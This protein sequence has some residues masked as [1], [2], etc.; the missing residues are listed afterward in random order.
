VQYW[1]GKKSGL[2]LA[3]ELAVS[4]FPK[5]VYSADSCYTLAG[6]FNGDGRTDI[7]VGDMVFFGDPTPG[8][9]L[10][11][12]GQS[13][14]VWGAEAHVAS[15]WNGDGISDTSLR[16]GWID[17]LW[18][19]PPNSIATKVNCSKTFNLNGDDKGDCVVIASFARRWDITAGWG[20]P[21]GLGPMT[22]V[23][24]LTPL[25]PTWTQTSSTGFAFIDAIPADVNGDGL[26]DIVVEAGGTDQELRNIWVSL[27]GTLH[28]V[29][30]PPKSGPR[31]GPS[32]RRLY[33]DGTDLVTRVDNGVGGVIVATYQSTSTLPD[34]AAPNVAGSIANVAPR[35]V[36]SSLQ[37]QNSVALVE[38]KQYAYVRGMITRSDFDVDEDEGF[39]VVRVKDSQTNEE[40]VTHYSSVGLIGSSAWTHRLPSVVEHYHSSGKL[41]QSQQ[42]SYDAAPLGFQGVFGP[43]SENTVEYEQGVV[44]RSIQKSYSYSPY[45]AV[46]QERECFAGPTSTPSQCLLT[47]T[48]VTDDQQRWLLNRVDAIRK[49][50]ENGVILDWERRYYGPEPHLLQ[51]TEKLLCDDSETCT[52]TPD[53]G[54]PGRVDRTPSPARWV[55]VDQSRMYDPAGDLLFHR[56]ALNH[57]TLYGY[58]YYTSGSVEPT[59]I[60]R[61]VTS[62]GMDL[63]IDITKT[64]GTDG[65]LGTESNESHFITTYRYDGLGRH[66]RTEY[67]DGAAETLI[68]ANVGKIDLVNPG[69]S[70]RVIIVNAPT[71]LGTPSLGNLFGQWTEQIFDGWGVVYQQRSRGDEGHVI[72]SERREE[73]QGVRVVTYTKPHFAGP[74]PEAVRVA[75]LDGRPTDIKRLTGS[76]TTLLRSYQYFTDHISVDDALGNRTETW[77]DE[78]SRV[79]VVTD[80]LFTSTHYSH[81][82]ADRIRLI[83]LANGDGYRASYD[84]WGRQ[85]TLFETWAGNS[86]STYDDV[87][88]LLTRTDDRPRSVTFTFDE[89][90]RKATATTSDGTT[91]FSYDDCPDG[92]GLLCAVSAFDHSESFSYDE[93]ARIRTHA[94]TD[95]QT[96]Q[97]LEVGY[98]YDRYGDLQGKVLP[99]TTQ[100]SYLRTDSGNLQSI[101]FYH[102]LEIASFGDYNALGKPGFRTDGAGIT[103]SYFYNPEGLLEQAT[104]TRGLFGSEVNRYA[105]GYDALGNVLSITDQ[106][107]T[108]NVDESQTF[109]YDPLLRLKTANGPYGSHNYQYD[110]S[111]IP[112]KIGQL[113]VERT[114]KRL[115]G[116]QKYV[117]ATSPGKITYTVADQIIADHDAAG[118]LTTAWSPTGT[119]NYEYNDEGELARVL[120]QGQPTLE[121]HYDAAGERYKKVFLSPG[122]D[123]IITLYLDG[124]ELRLKG[125]SAA[126][127]IHIGAP[128]VGVVASLT[129]GSV[130]ALPSIGTLSGLIGQP[131]AGTTTGGLI[132]G[133]QYYHANHI[134]S[135]SVVTDGAGQ[136]IGRYEYEPYGS[137]SNASRGYRSTNRSFTGQ[138]L[139][140]ETGL[141]YYGARY[142]LPIM[143]RF[144]SPD[145]IIPGGPYRPAALNRYA[146]VLNNPIR[147]LDPNGHGD[148][149]QSR[150]WWGAVA[151]E[152]KG[153][154][155]G[156]ARLLA[157]SDRQNASKLFQHY[158]QGTGTPYQLSEI[159]RQWQDWIVRDTHGKPGLHHMNPYDKGMYDLQNTLGHF[160]VN[161]VKNKDGSKTYN[162][163]DYYDFPAPSSERERHGFG[164]SDLKG[165]KLFAVMGMLPWTVYQAT[166]GLRERWEIKKVGK[167]M[168]LFIPQ[169]WLKSQGRS[170]RVK[171]GFLRFK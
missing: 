138:E 3:T 169:P 170:F 98:L 17:G 49:Q 89:L 21:I 161:V 93:R 71:A 152:T 159:P 95:V 76:A 56:D 129:S 165:W 39:E 128:E 26:T 103:S 140:E 108:K 44:A 158:V 42:F 84:N 134:G 114:G 135:I 25:V 157:G 94:L 11:A 28:E 91:I 73:I 167:E 53:E 99:D 150:P 100:I 80:A 46:T 104:A 12:V 55:P 126:T 86:T 162:L 15:D 1:L 8:A 163:S 33:A 141:L 145:S 154:A 125:S 75:Y 43:A 36:V 32:V 22:T 14:P 64:F 127:T 10:R 132:E 63:T 119:S 78:R 77:R 90:N 31:P 37:R 117:T 47:I 105:Y 54:C 148:E 96:G 29:W 51:K 115:R 164:V 142:Y 109:T 59:L 19:G 116:Y 79:S 133:M 112:Q 147:Y 131:L 23:A 160:D 50:V 65:T 111:G 151:G 121:L 24:N 153:L 70:Q 155:V 139:D 87:G 52:C 40:T 88:N 60:R 110:S 97:H 120:R 57:G 61:N 66:I 143:G 168:V 13:G 7:S 101:G 124:Y 130:V 136:E 85:R 16:L 82:S 9:N 137:V 4:D 156:V 123:P 83:A 30:T 118:Y 149:D 62:N 41:R 67:P 122:G 113:F 6:D 107:G 58:D 146:Y 81:D 166:T 72:E 92:L 45:G 106:R 68:Y 48:K 2:S 74:A 34:A 20:T 102:G 69:Q 18:K 38:K 144:L 35:F 27:S 5:C 171:G